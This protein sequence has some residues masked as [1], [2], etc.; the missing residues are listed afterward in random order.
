MRYFM[1]YGMH[2]NIHG[3]NVI[4]MSKLLDISTAWV[5]AHQFDISLYSRLWEWCS[6]PCCHGA[7][8]CDGLGVVQSCTPWKGPELTSGKRLSPLSHAYQTSCT[9]S[10]H[11]QAIGNIEPHVYY[12]MVVVAGSF[13]AR[14]LCLLSRDSNAGQTHQGDCSRQL[15]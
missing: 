13:I 15:G 5:L 7:R 9:I 3:N 2:G 6:S 11:Y 14:A 12:P 4:S 8:F 10:R 1:A